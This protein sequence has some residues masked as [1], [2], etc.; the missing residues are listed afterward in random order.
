MSQLPD[1]YHLQIYYSFIIHKKKE[2][3]LPTESCNICSR[4]R[5]RNVKYTSSFSAPRFPSQLWRFTEIWKCII[6]I[7]INIKRTNQVNLWYVKTCSLSLII[8]YSCHFIFFLLLLYI[9][10]FI[11]FPSWIQGPI[12]CTRE[13]AVEETTGEKKMIINI[14]RLK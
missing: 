8:L 12:L 4:I 5:H 1:N 11:W 13:G 10:I 6:K 14:N 2:K 9:F 3:E 7:L